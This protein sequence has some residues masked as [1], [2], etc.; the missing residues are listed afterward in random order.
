MMKEQSTTGASLEY[1][2]LVFDNLVKIFTDEDVD[3]S[4]IVAGAL[5]ATRHA[6]KYQQLKLF[7]GRVQKLI[8]LCRVA[9]VLTS[10]M[11]A[12][13][14]TEEL[15]VMGGNI[16]GHCV[17]SRLQLSKEEV[18]GGETRRLKLLSSDELS[19]FDLCANIDDSGICFESLS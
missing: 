12:N 5:P 18:N 10:Q 4:S 16:L 8:D 3:Q 19:S 14:K 9:V 6:D 11:R 2:L 13:L 17:H 1:G 15:T 7:L